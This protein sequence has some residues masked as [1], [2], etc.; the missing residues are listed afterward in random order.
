MYCHGQSCGE[1]ASWMGQAL[2]FHSLYTHTAF[3]CSLDS[4]TTNQ[5]HPSKTRISLKSSLEVQ[6][7]PLWYS[8]RDQT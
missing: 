4:L 8:F 5:R 1:M 3:M 2:L 7:A 6:A